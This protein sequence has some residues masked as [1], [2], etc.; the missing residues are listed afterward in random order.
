MTLQGN[1]VEPVGQLERGAI[2]FAGGVPCAGANQHLT[3]AED[4]VGSHALG[5]GV[6]QQI[7]RRHRMLPGT[8]HV[9]DEVEEHRE[10][11][12]APCHEVAVPVL[13]RPLVDLPDHLT[14]RGVLALAAEHVGLDQLRALL[15][16]LVT[17]I[18]RPPL[19]RRR[20]RIGSVGVGERHHL[21][22]IQLDAEALQASLIRGGD[23]GAPGG[24][25]ASGFRGARNDG[26]TGCCGAARMW[27][28]AE[29][30][31]PR[32]SALHGRL[33]VCHDKVVR[34]DIAQQVD[35]PAVTRR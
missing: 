2:A 8:R 28:H 20:R 33:M 18:A 17:E 22:D 29:H 14:A 30:D 32:P 27:S 7:D 10:Q 24:R 16:D 26:Q 11:A 12:M 25:G 3:E 35:H 1:V 34:S 5:H 31:R 15:A 4:V 6:V 13:G 21:H 19:Q 9:A 23:V